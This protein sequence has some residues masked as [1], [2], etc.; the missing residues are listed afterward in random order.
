MTLVHGAVQDRVFSYSIV[1]SF[2]KVSIF[3]VKNWH[4]SYPL[5]VRE[6]LG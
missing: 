1:Y 3:F 5:I 2:K 4:I 6:A